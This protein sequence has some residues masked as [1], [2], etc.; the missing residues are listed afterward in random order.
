MTTEQRALYY[1]LRPVAYAHQS[2]VAVPTR[3]LIKTAGNVKCSS[4]IVGQRVLG[5]QQ[6]MT[7]TSTF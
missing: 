1:L 2:C 7:A 3:I 5:H 4:N 6:R